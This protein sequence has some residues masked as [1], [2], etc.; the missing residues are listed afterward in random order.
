M[1]LLPQVKSKADPF[2]LML[3][4]MTHRIRQSLDLSEIL[5]ATVIEVRTFLGT[6]RVK[7]Y[8]FHEDESGEVIAE[9][10]NH[11]Q[12]PSLL[13]H[14]FPAEDIPE[15]ARHLFLTARMRSIV[16]VRAQKIGVSPPLN[17][18][19][20]FRS[21]DPCHVDY[22]TAMGVQSSLVV[23]ILDG[24]RLWGLLVSHHSAS[25]SIKGSELKMMQLIADQVSIAIAQ[26]NLLEQTRH[27]FRARLK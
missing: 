16:D 24:E 9:S 3:H 23:P 5:N 22:L 19:V 4:R 17:A 14:N 10:I 2:A 20:Q 27:R 1:P 8:R 11:Q 15:A 12:L 7:I 6:D 21:V 13:G 18:D 25:R 26:S